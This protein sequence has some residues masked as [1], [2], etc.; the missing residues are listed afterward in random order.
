MS[1]GRVLG[2]MLRKIM[3]F[4]LHWWRIMKGSLQAAPFYSRNHS[5]VMRT[6]FGNGPVQTFLCDRHDVLK[7]SFMGHG[8]K[9]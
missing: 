9:R 1:S 6:I 3:W 8:D 2:T 5:S 4:T 7:C